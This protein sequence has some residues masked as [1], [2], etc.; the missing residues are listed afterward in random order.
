MKAGAENIIEMGDDFRL[1][2]VISGIANGTTDDNEFDQMGDAVFHAARESIV[3]TDADNNILAVNAGFTATS[4]Y[5]EFE[6]LGKKPEL[7]ASGRED[8]TFFKRM[9]DATQRKGHWE[10]EVWSRRK[11]GEVYPEWLSVSVMRDGDGRIVRHIAIYSD[12]SE[13]KRDEL[14]LRHRAHHDPLTNL[15]NRALGL[16]RL[17]HA[18]ATAHRGRTMVSVMFVDLDAFKPVND[19]FGHQAGDDLLCQVARRMETCIRESDTVYRFGGDEFVVILTDITSDSAATKVANNLLSAL[20]VPFE[21]A[22]RSVAISASIGIAFYP[23][24]G[25]EASALVRVADEAMYEAKR[26]G[27]NRSMTAPQKKTDAA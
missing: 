16:D 13:R 7:F 17:A 23:T 21:I 26:S 3:V 15:P 8:S 12:N 19:M 5:E 14:A 2:E 25:E 1:N 18:L 6:V 9:W 10:G 22:K 20:A 24:H 27:K 4:G 11:N